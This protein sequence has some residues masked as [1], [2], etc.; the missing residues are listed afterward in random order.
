[1]N[2]LRRLISRSKL[3]K[4]KLRILLNLTN[5]SYKIQG[6]LNAV[7]LNGDQAENRTFREKTTVE[8]KRS[9][10]KETDKELVL[11]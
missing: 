11:F 10:V 5:Y 2:I 8:L 4:I 3:I 7:S 1:M 6:F 9:E